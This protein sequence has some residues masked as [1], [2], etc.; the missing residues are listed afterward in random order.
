MAA[1][2]QKAERTFVMLPP[3]L[4]EKAKKFAESEQ[5]SLSAII[6]RGLKQYVEQ[7]TCKATK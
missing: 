5:L 2:T 7:S 6:R 4:K 1:V 3:A